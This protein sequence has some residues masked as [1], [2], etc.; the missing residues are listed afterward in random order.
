MEQRFGTK[1][2]RKY[3]G[4]AVLG[5]MLLG[6]VLAMTLATPARA[7]AASASCPTAAGEGGGKETGME[8]PTARRIEE[9]TPAPTDAAQPARTEVAVFA[10]G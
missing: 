10:L 4:K 5:V 9:A 2:K 8:T 6:A 7:A 3:V 1:R